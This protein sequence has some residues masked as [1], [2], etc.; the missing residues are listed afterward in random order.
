MRNIIGLQLEVRFFQSLCWSDWKFVICTSSTEKEN[1]QDILRQ[2]YKST[3]A[4]S[5]YLATTQ[6]QPHVHKLSIIW[7]V[8]FRP[9]SVKLPLDLSVDV[10]F[11]CRKIT[12]FGSEL[13]MC[14]Q[15]LH[16]RV[17]PESETL[18]F[19]SSIR[20][21]WQL[22]FLARWKSKSCRARSETSCY[23]FIIKE[24]SELRAH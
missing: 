11:F 2:V 5:L 9:P 12:Q 14:A 8:W 15:Q 4:H 21:F 1:K 18:L 16:F 10:L 17:S 19:L 22:W 3:E 24:R 7:R 20:P 23:L 6:W 13:W